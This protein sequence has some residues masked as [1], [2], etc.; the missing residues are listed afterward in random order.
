M[1]AK[2]LQSQMARRG[3]L[4]RVGLGA[5]VVGA[6]VAGVS[7]AEPQAAVD[8]AW[9]PARH[10]QDDWYDKIPGVHRFVCDSSTPEG[11][12]WALQFMNNFYNANQD[13]YGLKEI[14]LA[15]IIIA[16]HRATEFAY[17]DS[18]WAKYGKGI[19][20]HSEFMDP[21]TKEAPVINPYLATAEGYPQQGRLNGLLKKGVQFAV[22]AS[23]S[24]GI[25][26]RIAAA[27]GGKT[28][29]IFKEITASLIPNSH[30]VPAGVLAVNRA[31]EH[32]YSFIYAI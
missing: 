5:G 11:F 21:K 31:Q 3:F 19:T 1:N 17:T 10:S 18:I 12:G 16:R 32:G 7:A 30:L 14:D 26:G 25:A 24:R 6:S 22:C 2:W 13:G 27:T 9:K 4:A 8:A 15:V 23:S 20:E 28:D 29:E